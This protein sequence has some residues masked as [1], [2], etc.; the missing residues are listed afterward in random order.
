MMN[1]KKSMKQRFKLFFFNFKNRKQKEKPK[2][3]YQLLCECPIKNKK[4]LPNYWLQLDA[5]GKHNWIKD[6]LINENEY[7]EEK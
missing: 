1:E 4:E 6:N 7:L 2:T 3:K 5:K